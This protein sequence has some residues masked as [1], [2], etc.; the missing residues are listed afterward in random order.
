MLHFI[1]VLEADGKGVPIKIIVCREIYGMLQKAMLVGLLGFIFPGAYLVGLSM[2]MC[3]RAIRRTDGGDNAVLTLTRMCVC[4]ML[5]AVCACVHVCSV[6]LCDTR[7]RT[8]TG[9]I[10]QS[11]VG[12]LISSV[13]L[14]AFTSRMPYTDQRTNI[15]AIIAQSIQAFSYFS[16]ILLKVDMNGEVLTSRDIGLIMIR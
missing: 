8:H 2:R 3:A 13:F 7:T 10:L 15:L 6:L 14:L 9:K 5:C 11:A 16:T 12:L 4:S 1:Y